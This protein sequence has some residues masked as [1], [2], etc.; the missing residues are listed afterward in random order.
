MFAIIEM[1]LPTSLSLSRMMVFS[2]NTVIAPDSIGNSSPFNVRCISAAVSHLTTM[3]MVGLSSDSFICKLEHELGKVLARLLNVWLNS[4]L[5]REFG[6]IISSS[7]FFTSHSV[8]W[9]NPNSWQPTIVPQYGCN[10]KWL[11]ISVYGRWGKNIRREITCM[12]S[13]YIMNYNIYHDFIRG[14]RGAEYQI[15]SCANAGFRDAYQVSVR[16]L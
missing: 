7:I 10:Y 2:H 6:S 4:F 15:S 14:D 12:Y 16:H 1:W 11:F 8:F 9:Y 5:F 13:W 3:W